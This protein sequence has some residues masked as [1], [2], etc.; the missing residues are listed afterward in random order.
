MAKMK[1][2][3]H[4]VYGSKIMPCTCDHVFQ[5]QRYGRFLRLHNRYIKPAPGGWRCTVCERTK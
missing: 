1:K 5:D 2:V 3:E 4:Q